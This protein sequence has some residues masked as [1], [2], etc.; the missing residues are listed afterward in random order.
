MDGWMIL[1]P[2]CHK[3]S[4]DPEVEGV[5]ESNKGVCNGLLPCHSSLHRLISAL[6]QDELIL[7]AYEI[8]S[9]R[10]S[11]Y[12]PRFLIFFGGEKIIIYPDNVVN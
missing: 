1:G 6:T 5:R 8:I 10:Q 7:C 2:I 12:F 9:S 3:M 11:G 4:D